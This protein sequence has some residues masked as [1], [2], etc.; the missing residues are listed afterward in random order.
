M[1]SIILIDKIFLTE[2]ITADWC[3]RK[4]KNVFDCS[5]NCNNYSG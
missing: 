4:Q 1:K 2:D 3:E 5:N